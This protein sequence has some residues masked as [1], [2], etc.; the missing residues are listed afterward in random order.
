[1]PSSYWNAVNAVIEEADI[2]L[3]V[4]DSRHIDATRNA[5]IEAK[6]R[7]SGKPLIFVFTKCDLAER[8]ALEERSKE[9]FP[10][11]Y[12]SSKTYH[13]IKLLRDRILIEAKR[14]GVRLPRVGVLG[15]PNMGKSS[16]I[17]ALNGSASARTSAESGF[18]KGKQYIKARGF[19]LIDT[20]GVLAYKEVDELTKAVTG[21]NTNVKDPEGVVLRLL[22]SRPGILEAQ[23]NAV[24]E[25][26][27]AEQSLEAI[28]RKLNLLLK[29]GK[30]D[31]KN[32]AERV[33]R[34]LRLGRVKI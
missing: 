13:G 5:E 34:D 7:R 26:G 18:T 22:D 21:M 10:C 12:V 6:V 8:K 16:L 23:Y 3:E 31:T 33:L 17:N 9:F 32:A 1:M 4:I 14:A 20:P 28:A 25:G 11:L 27:D 15:Y 30:A 2:L 24:F 19:T 29:G